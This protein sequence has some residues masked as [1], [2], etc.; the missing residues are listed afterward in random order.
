MTETKCK[1]VSNAKKQGQGQHQDK[2]TQKSA[3][4]SLSEVPILRFRQSNN[5]FIKF[6]EALST[7]A[8]IEFGDVGNQSSW[9]HIMKLLCRKKR[10][11][12]FL[13]MIK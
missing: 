6:R 4:K 11:T 3:D 5:N 1:T 8:L 9:E 10:T 7:A 13:E 12:R 2:I